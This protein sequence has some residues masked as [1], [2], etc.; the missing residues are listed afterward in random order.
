M[1]K[2]K[3][4][5]G[6]MGVNFT[7]ERELYSRFKTVAMAQRKT[8]KDLLREVIEKH[9]QSFEH[10]QLVEQISKIPPEERLGLIHAANQEERAM[11][12]DFTL[13]RQS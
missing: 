4:K 3:V 10:D 1:E 13:K 5:D 8:V 11:E 12:Q 9:T 2:V 6:W 7:I